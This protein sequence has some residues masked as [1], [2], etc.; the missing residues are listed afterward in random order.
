MADGP[1]GQYGSDAGPGQSFPP[2]TRRQG[3]AY[4]TSRYLTASEKIY[5]L[6]DNRFRER[7]WIAGGAY[8]I[9]DMATYPWS[10]YLEKHGFDPKAFPALLSWRER[11][12]ARAAVATAQAGWAE[13]FAR[14]T[15][16]SAKIATDADFD[17]FFGRAENAPSA[18]YS[19]L[20]H[21]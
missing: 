20:R 6:L 1:D 7:E 18:D 12:A 13:A 17:R 5:R 16:A 11:I 19:N 4:A 10:M 2:V 21:R 3:D 15:R 9:A 8:S 14:Q